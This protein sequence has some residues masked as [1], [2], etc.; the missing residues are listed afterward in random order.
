MPRKWEQFLTG[1]RNQRT[2]I[3]TRRHCCARGKKGHPCSSLASA[4]STRPTF[5]A[6][7]QMGVRATHTTN[8]YRGGRRGK[9]RPQSQGKSGSQLLATIK[10]YYATHILG[11]HRQT[12]ELTKLML[13]LKTLPT[14][15][16]A[17]A[18]ATTKSCAWFNYR[19]SWFV[20]FSHTPKNTKDMPRHPSLAPA[21]PP[22]PNSASSRPAI[23]GQ[24]KVRAR[25]W[26]SL[27]AIVM[28][29]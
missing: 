16:A 15:T 17:T 6:G 25:N 7:A 28:T 3:M 13:K 10:F 19:I 14:T 2:V 27:P 5:P 20:K 11:A 29:T 9:L 22:A 23:C 24:G 1:E 12:M 4:A 21:Q 18:T 26:F 8:N